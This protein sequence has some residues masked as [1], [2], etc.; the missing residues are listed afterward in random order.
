MTKCEN[1]KVTGAIFHCALHAGIFS[2]CCPFLCHLL[3]NCPHPFVD[4]RL[5]LRLFVPS[6]P[7]VCLSLSSPASSVKWW[8][9]SPH[10][11]CHCHP[12]LQNWSWQEWPFLLWSGKGPAAHPRRMTSSIFW[13]WRKKA[14]YISWFNTS[15]FHLISSLLRVIC[16][17]FWGAGFCRL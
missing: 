13:R 1:I 4:V 5:S 16:L 8:T 14:R 2:T 10:A 15:F 9:C 12:S 7:V 11:V 6:S 3:Y 17:V